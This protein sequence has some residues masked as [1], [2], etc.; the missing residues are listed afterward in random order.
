MRR[1]NE[2]FGDRIPCD[3]GIPR[4]RPLQN[5]VIPAKAGDSADGTS[6]QRGGAI[7]DLSPKRS[8]RGPDQRICNGLPERGGV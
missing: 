5:F 8:L 2:G 1:V 4:K 3:S 6:I 7:R